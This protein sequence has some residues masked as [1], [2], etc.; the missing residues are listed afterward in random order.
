MAASHNEAAQSMFSLHFRNNLQPVSRYT[1]QRAFFTTLTQPSL[2]FHTRQIFQP[3]ETTPSTGFSLQHQL[4]QAL[5][6]SKTPK[7]YSH[8]KY[9]HQN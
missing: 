4:K 5:A 3:L 8:H 6:V 7:H 1:S 2:L 9:K